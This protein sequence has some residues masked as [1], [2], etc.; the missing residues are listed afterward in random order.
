MPFSGEKKMWPFW[1]VT[2]AFVLI[3]IVSQL[4][5]DGAFMD[6][7]LYVTVGKNLAEGYGTFWQPH[8]SKVDLPF[9]EQPPLYF[10]LLALF[11]KVLGTSMYVERLFCFTCF[12]LTGFYIHKLWKCIFIQNE[13]IAVLSWLPVLFWSTIPIC[14]WAYTNFVEETVMTLF[15]VMAVYYSFI[16][17]FLE[18]RTIYNLIIAGVFIFLATLTK[19]FQG[20]FPVIAAGV[21]WI[22]TKKISF[23]KMLFYSLILTGVPFLIYSFL[24]LSN[25]SVYESFQTYFNKRLVTTF[26][27][28]NATTNDRT[29]LLQQLFFHLL[30]ILCVSLITWLI[31]KKHSTLTS[32]KTSNKQVIVWLI[33]IGL[34]GSLPLMVT[35]EQRTWYLVT[36]LPFF[37]IAISIYTASNIQGFINKINI[38]SKGFKFFHRISWTLFF[39]SILFVFSQ[40]G[41]T[42]RDKEVLADVYT[43]GKIIPYGSIITI[44]P[45]MCMDF[46]FKEYMIRY[47]YISSDDSKA[48]HHY[49]ISKKELPC[50]LV[51]KEYKRYSVETQKF[52]LYVLPE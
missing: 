41:N 21:F 47:F 45:P 28:I 46:N 50:D 33:I 37:A 15:V 26:N 3:L 20:L 29:F 51:P 14:F 7:M 52:D 22:V 35:L 8:I 6:G 40:I 16:G 44:P 31:A 10:G 12:S 17:L 5:Q 23:W 30:P 36:S 38:N 49:L 13:K 2:F 11:Y 1:L 48:K 19:G 18:K 25:H 32:E 27:G 4:I 24:V 43:F 9:H 42:K 34:S 39:A